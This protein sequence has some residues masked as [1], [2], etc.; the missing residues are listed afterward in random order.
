MPNFPKPDALLSQLDSRGL[1]GAEIYF[2]C[3]STLS[4]EFSGKSYKSKEFSEDAGYGV[5]ILKNK[6]AGFSHT[7]LPGDFQ[8]AAKTAEKLSAISPKS[9]FFFEPQ[10]KKYP[11]PRTEDPKLKGLPPEIAFSAIR[12]VLEAIRKHAEPTRVSVSLSEGSESIANT[13]G[14]YAESNCT[15]IS[16]YA[17]A[18]KGR[19]LGYSLYSSRFLPKSFSK[20][21]IEA[22]KIAS[23]MAASKPIPSQKLTVKFSPDMLSSLL[24]FLL[25]SF[26][27]DNKRRGIT[28]LKKGQKKFSR[29]FTLLSDP[30]APAD[31]SC[32]FDGEGVPSSPVSL[33]KEGRVENFLYDR[34]TA[35]LEGVEAKGS[36]QR[37]DYASSPSPGITNLVISPG[38]YT[39]KGP[40]KF[41]EALSFHGLH[42][43][44]PVSGDFGVSMD[45]GFLHEKGKKRPVTDILLTGNIF[46]LF[47]SIRHLGKAR[48][49]KGNFVS[50]EI[51]FSNVQIVGK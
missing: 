44:D 11:N 1:S 35:A 51:W 7:N 45:I 20:F 26:D 49:M 12:E 38:K 27:G 14:L 48:T 36:C 46:N 23:A 28:K 50:P 2:T 30:L 31:S 21:G 40:S 6:K 19:G 34:Y 9:T 47:N 37:T 43:S 33:V 13:S 22:G 16:I 41:L 18:K 10:H 8:K 3:A 17:E 15:E 29:A 4:V 32:P 25:F 42:T 5:R 24:N 39:G